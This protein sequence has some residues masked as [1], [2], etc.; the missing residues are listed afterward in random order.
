MRWPSGRLFSCPLAST[1]GILAAAAY[2]P[3]FVCS[4]GSESPCCLCSCGRTQRACIHHKRRLPK[5][6]KSLDAKARIRMKG[7][8]CHALMRPRSTKHCE[9]S[10]SSTCPSSDRASGS[11]ATPCYFPFRLGLQRLARS[12][13]RCFLAAK[14]AYRPV[15]TY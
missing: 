7:N 2:R 13:N 12:R 4:S 1:K 10:E 11:G 3:C 15:W 6:L 8:G 5:E 9:N 14:A